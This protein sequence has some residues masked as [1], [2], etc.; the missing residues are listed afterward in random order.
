MAAN[1]QIEY[2]ESTAEVDYTTLYCRRVRN[3]DGFDVTEAKLQEWFEHM[4]SYLRKEMVWGGVRVVIPRER[5]GPNYASFY[6]FVQ[7]EHPEHLHEVINALNK[8][9]FMGVEIDLLYKMTPGMLR[10]IPEPD[11]QWLH[12]AIDRVEESVDQTIE[13]PVE[14]PA[15]QQRGR[16]GSIRARN[17]ALMKQVLDLLAENS[18]LKAELQRKEEVIQELKASGRKSVAQR[19]E[20]AGGKD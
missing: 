15:R 9:S 17:D 5:Q 8:Q 7:F 11:E 6:A 1:N 10:A 12:D 16:E 2:Y 20:E 13:Q 3:V 14:Q 18:A 19:L 4:T